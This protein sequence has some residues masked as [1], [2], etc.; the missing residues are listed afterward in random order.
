MEKLVMIGGGGHCKSALDAALKSG[1]F[2]EIVVTDAA[3]PSDAKLLGCPV[4][5]TDEALPALRERGFRCAHVAVGSVGS[6]A[7]RRK[8]AERAA[9]LGFRFPAI[10]DS[11]AVV[12]A[13]VAIGDGT[14]V[15]KNAVLNAGCAIGSHC[16]VNTG[17]IAEHDCAVGDF[18]HIAVGAIL[19]GGVKVG[20][21]AFVGAGATVIQGLAIGNRAVIGANSVVLRNLR[22]GETAYG[23]VKRPRET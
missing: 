21:D 2:S 22:E 11:S 17:A 1:L 6:T 14:F 15:G 9:R 10:V 16:I 5:G 7:L 12:A 3:F 19:C 23:V 20:A 4:V 13:D 18:S 8:L